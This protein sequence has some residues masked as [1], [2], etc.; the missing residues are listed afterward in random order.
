MTVAIGPIRSGKTFF[1]NTLATHFLKYG[2]FL[3]A[4]DIDPGTETLAK[5][6]GKEGGIFRVSAD[7]A[8]GLNPF[9]P[10][11]GKGDQQFGAH[12]TELLL[13]MLH[14][15]DDDDMRRLEP[16]EQEA[17][18]SAISKTVALP[19]QMR[20][21]STLCAHMPANL[22]RKFLRWI[23]EGP[24]GMQGRYSHLFDNVTDA[25]GHLDKRVAVFNM[26]AV[27]DDPKALRPI[28]L[29][30]F[31]RITLAFEDPN[32]RNLPKILDIDEAHQAL[33]IPAFSDYIVKK[34]RTWGKW[35]ASVQLWTQSPEELGRV[36]GWAAIRSA[37]STFIFMA[38][39]KMDEQMY[40]E[41]FNLRP[42]ECEAIRK[43][44]PRR[45]AY[46]VQPELGVSKRLIVDVEP[47]QYVMNTSHPREAELRDRLIA[48]M[49]YEQGIAATLVEIERLKSENTASQRSLREAPVL[50]RVV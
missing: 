24:G 37:A 36:E 29:E 6:F 40:M 8:S 14:A 23:K 20:T 45:E 38:D 25:I 4:V 41:T 28:L 31:Y 30:L 3:R 39:P 35:G 13:E 5:A 42:G 12:L 47:E 1:K 10:Y 21:M 11:R 49:G 16:S 9:A 17:L 44:T 33:A 34:I 27:R 22:H 46:I 19:P 43:L 15:N 50:T 18:D 7:G 32:I 2:G 48:E 26:Q